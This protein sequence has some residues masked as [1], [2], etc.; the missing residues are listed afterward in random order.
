VNVGVK[1]RV[2]SAVSVGG[3]VGVCVGKT[4]EGVGVTVAGGCE[5]VSEGNGPG[6]IVGGEVVIRL[7]PPHAMS[8]RVRIE[9][10]ANKFLLIA[11]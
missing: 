6:I 11:N 2:G 8:E 10:Q 5:G 4:A 7:N 3:R 1:L 9:M